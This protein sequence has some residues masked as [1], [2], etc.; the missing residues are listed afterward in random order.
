MRSSGDALRSQLHPHMTTRLEGKKVKLAVYSVWCNRTRFSRVSLEPPASFS[1]HVNSIYHGSAGRH[2]QNRMPRYVNQHL[3]H[4]SPIHTPPTAFLVCFTTAL[5]HSVIHS[6]ASAFQS[7][8]FLPEKTLNRIIMP[9]ADDSLASC[10][11]AGSS[12]YLVVQSFDCVRTA[13][14][15]HAL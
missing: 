3:I 1:M 8:L 11:P 15:E 12:G 5:R 4:T 2:Y 10:R 9:R 6:S 7:V 14:S 13:N